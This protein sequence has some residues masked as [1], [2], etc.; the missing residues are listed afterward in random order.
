MAKKFSFRGKSLEEL[1]AMPRAEFTK[2][3]TSRARRSLKRGMSP[4]QKKFIAKVGRQGKPARTHRRDPIVFPGMV[5]STIM[6][7]NG[8]EFTRFDVVPEMIGHRLGEFS[9]SRPKVKHSAPGM[10]ATRSSKFVSLK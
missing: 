2:L 1:Q 8:K 4:L 9:Q 7:Y 6:V 3:L 5:G 10:G